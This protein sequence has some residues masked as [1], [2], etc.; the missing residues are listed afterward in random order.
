MAFDDDSFIREVNEDMRS[1]FFKEM[2]RRY[3]RLIIS[4]AVL[5]VAGTAAKSGYE[6][7][8]TTQASA[9]GDK[10][11]SAMKLA[12]DKKTDESIAAFKDLE[13]GGFGSYPVLARMRAATLIA[14]KGDA[15]GA[16]AA[17]KA[18]GTDTS[19]PQAIR[20]AA[21]LRAAFIMIDNGTYDEVSAEVQDMAIPANT[22]RNSAR[23]ALG[24][25]AFK[26]GDLKKANERFKQIA[27]DGQAPR[28]VVTRAQMLLDLIAASGQ[29]S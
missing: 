23:E 7:Y 26:A 28:N 19:I 8:R 6:Y 14:E 1:D 4:V 5:I 18:I 15:K 2:W 17:F 25:A 12:N 3:G 16:I 20:D 22:F 27:D 13:A 24:L 11:L 9:S 10:F 21:R 29:A